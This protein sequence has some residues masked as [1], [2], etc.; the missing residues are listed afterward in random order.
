MKKLFSIAKKVTKM[1]YSKNK[2][3]VIIDLLQSIFSALIP[4]VSIY[5]SSKIVDSI[6]SA[7]SIKAREIIIIGLFAMLI[8][9]LAS[10]LSISILDYFSDLLFRRTDKNYMDSFNKKDYAKIDNHRH[11]ESFAQI[12]SMEKYMGTTVEVI[13]AYLLNFINSFVTVI[14]SFIMFIGAFN[15]YLP[16]T[17]RYK[18]I[19]SPIIIFLFF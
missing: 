9:M 11:I 8:I 14:L 17:S 4:L 1:L 2:S 3:L 15:K 6:I 7:D 10:N 12:R 13:F 18:F 16:Q 19:D 5:I